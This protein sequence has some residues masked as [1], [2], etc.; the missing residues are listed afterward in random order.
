VKREV[1]LTILRVAVLASLGGAAAWLVIGPPATLFVVV[2]A[3]LW[4]V[5][6]FDNWTGSCLMLA[7]LLLLVIGILT[8]LVG[9]VAL[10]R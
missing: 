10:P 7:V 1:A 2:V 3:V 9:M 6:R 8:F 4:L 5:W